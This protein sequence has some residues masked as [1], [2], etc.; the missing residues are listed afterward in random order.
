MSV[1]LTTDR[2][3]LRW[4]VPEDVDNM[5]KILSD[6]V[7]MKHYPQT[8]NRDE[9]EQLWVARNLMRYERDGHGFFMCELKATGEFVGMAGQLIQEIDGVN[10]FEVGYL[11]V[12]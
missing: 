12:R 7:A 11:L 10:E 6:P 5:L 8:Y 3:R 2:L 9:V 1:E 4:M